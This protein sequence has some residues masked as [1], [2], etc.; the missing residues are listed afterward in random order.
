MHGWLHR[1]QQSI[2]NTAQPGF[3]PLWLIAAGTAK[4][5]IPK[6]AVRSVA[7]GLHRQL[8]AFRHRRIQ[9]TINELAGDHSQRY[10]GGSPWLMHLMSPMPCPS[11]EP[12]FAANREP[13]AAT[14]ASGQFPAQHASRA[15]W[16]SPRRCRFSRSLAQYDNVCRFRL[17]DRSRPRAAPLREARASSDDARRNASG[18]Q[19]PHAFAHHQDRG[20]QTLLS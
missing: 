19:K 12:G 1:Q 15:P 17:W 6:I 18:E 16:M 7:E 9:R 14:R 13:P 11:P 5:R 3:A 10:S 2:D 4:I 20:I 8:P